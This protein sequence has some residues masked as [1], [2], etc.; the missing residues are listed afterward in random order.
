VHKVKLYLDNNVVS[1]IAKNDTP[2]ETDALERLLE[3]WNG[4]KVDLVTSELTLKEIQAYQHELKRRLV[5]QTYQ[6]LTKVPVVRWDEL[7]G[8]RSYGNQH[9]WINTPDIKNDRDYSALLA[10]SLDPADAQHIFVAVKNGC[11]IFLT[12][13][14]PVLHRA[15]AIGQQFHLQVQKPSEFVSSRRS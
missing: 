8:I 2:S 13:D 5:E 6:S 14:R 1:A 7:A 15:P 12:C 4:K 10:L 9:T 3:A 11:D